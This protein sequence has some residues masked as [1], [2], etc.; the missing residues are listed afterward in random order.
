MAYKKC[1]CA[2]ADKRLE[3]TLK[4]FGEQA[5]RMKFFDDIYLYSEDHLEKAFYEHFHDKFT[6]RGFGYWVWKPQVILQTLEKMNYGDILLYA[7]AGCILTAKGLG[8]L[9]ESFEIANNSETGLL[10]FNMPWCSE[11]EWTKGDVF[12]Y[13]GVRGREDIFE[14]QLVGGVLFVKKSDRAIGIIRKWL[15]V[16]YDDFSLV[17]DSPSKSPDFME[18]KEH[19]HDQ[20]IWSIL[21][22]INRIP[23]LS[24]LE[25]ES[26][27]KYP[28]YTARDKHWEGKTFDYHYEKFRRIFNVKRRVIKMAKVILPVILPPKIYRKIKEAYRKSL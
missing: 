20:S 12:D 18:F 16:F 17:D 6:S 25:L 10:G 11:K 8:R 19:R 26:P 1:I 27:R 7:D 23:C 5:E 21:G 15:Q 22:K 9:L 2:F 28:I 24:C 4:R 14:G 13:F 3:L